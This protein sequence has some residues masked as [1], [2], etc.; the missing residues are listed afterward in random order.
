MNRKWIKRMIAIALVV[1]LLVGGYA[2]YRRLQAPRAN[3]NA[4]YMVARAQIGDIELNVSASG[5]VVAAVSQEVVP[6]V[7]GAV[8]KL[9]VKEGDRV[10]EGDVIAVIDDES[11]QQ[12]IEK[13]ES[14]LKQQNLS[15]SK[16]KASLSDF[17]IKAPADGRIK[18]LKA[19]VGEDVGI[20]TRTYGALAIISTDGK[21]KV[22]IKPQ[23]NIS[24]TE[25][26][27]VLV[28]LDDGTEVEGTVVDTSL[29]QPTG[30]S[31]QQD[32]QAGPS[33]GS[34]QVQINRDDLPIGA[35]VT[36]LK[37][38]E[39]SGEYVVIGEGTLDVNQGVSVT[40]NNGKISVIYVKENSV[41]KRG[42]NLF[43]LDDSDVKANI[44]SQNLAIEQTQ[45]ELESKKS[46]LEVKSPIN[47]II[48][49]LTVKVGDQVQQGKAIATIIDPTQLNVVVAVD[50]LDIPKVKI[51]QKAKIKV[52]AFPDTVFEGEVIKIADIG[53]SSG[54]GVTTFDVTISIKDPGDVRIGMSATAEIQVESKKGVVLLPIEAIQE[55]NGEKYVI[56]APSS[57]QDKSGSEEVTAEKQTSEGAT[58][59]NRNRAWGSL[60]TG[61]GRGTQS[62]NFFGRSSFRKVE[63][64]LTNETYAE[65]ISGVEEGEEVIIPLSS[66]VS[67]PNNWRGMFPGFGGMRDAF[68]QG[69]FNRSRVPANIRR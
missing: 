33:T 31:G 41:V 34:V 68:P 54:G 48:T 66:T 14:N 22:T 56:I 21:M 5:T 11:L 9:E 39:N 3:A 36:V 63:V 7:S 23:G 67:T 42:D 1:L 16:L 35:K 50:E 45:K 69:G 8:E 19:R 62:G 58:A 29:S 2:V 18:S 46:Q 12:E 40:G 28:R 27:K 37:R 61:D 4:N 51:G 24:L 30:P 26:E 57:L 6:L 47:G 25:G 43:K 17:Y 13:I 60:V 53:Q 65:I 38:D 10:K 64:G 15:L 55:R 49:S 20:T 59:R 44:E 32:S 52:D